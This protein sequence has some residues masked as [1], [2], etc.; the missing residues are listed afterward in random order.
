MNKKEKDIIKSVVDNLLEL[1]YKILF[2]DRFDNIENKVEYIRQNFT[3]CNNYTGTIE[4]INLNADISKTIELDSELVKLNALLPIK[5]QDKELIDLAQQMEKIQAKKYISIAEFTEIYGKSKTSQQGLRGRLKDP[6][7]Y[8]Q[9]SK[10]SAIL[11]EVELVE[12]WFKN[13]YKQ[14]FEP[15]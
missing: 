3:K 2:G 5:E 13:Q 1:R 7:P 6:I 8:K 15:I 4:F 10:N 11:Y 14:Y 9:I 12:K